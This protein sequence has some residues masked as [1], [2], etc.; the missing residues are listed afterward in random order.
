MR[1]VRFGGVW[2]ALLGLW[3]CDD[4]GEPSQSQVS[5]EF[6]SPNRPGQLLGCAEDA[7]RSTTDRLE[8]DVSVLV[9]LKG[10]PSEGL[11]VSLREVGF[12]DSEV[13]APVPVSG[14]V[15]FPGYP[16][17]LGDLNLAV[18]VR[19][20]NTVLASSER[21][22]L[23]ALNPADPACGAVPVLS[24]V[25]PMDGAVLDGAGD[26]N[27][28]DDLQLE[29]AVG[30]EGGING[31][32]RL[33]IDEVEAG[34]AAPVDGVARFPV[35]LPI[36]NG[37]GSFVL[38]AVATSAAGGE[39]RTEITVQVDIDGCT[40][41]VTPADVGAGCDFTT[42][43]DED[44]ATD[45]IQVTFAAETTCGQVAFQVN[46]I[47]TPLLEAVD[48]QVSSVLTLR[49]GVNEI[50][51]TATTAGGLATSV[52]P[53]TLVVGPAQPATLDLA[54]AAGENA[55]DLTTVEAEG[56]VW[57]LS[58]SSTDLPVGTEVRLVLDPA[59][60][61]APTGV[62]AE[63]GT[64][65]AVVATPFLCPAT[66]R[67][68]ATDACGEAVE[69]PLY[70]VCFDGVRPTLTIIEPGDGA[71]PVDADAEAAGLQTAVR[72]RVA[73]ERPLP[74]F[75]Y[76]IRVECGRGDGD[77]ADRTTVSALRSSG[78]AQG[79]VTVQVTF[80]VGDVGD[81]RCRATDLAGPNGAV[82]PAV[83]YRIEFGMPTFRLVDPSPIGEP[84][85]SADG[86][87]RIAG[88]GAAL[89]A[90]NA[91]M[92]A[93]IAAAGQVPL[94]VV[95]AEEGP[96]RFGATL[97]DAGQPG[98]LLDG[99]YGVT[100]AGVSD[101]GPVAVNP[102]GAV[103]FVV[104]S[105]APV[106][107]LVGPAGPLGAAND[108]NNDLSDCIQ[109]P[110]TLRLTDDTA[111]EICF[112]I[113]GEA[114]IC[115]TVDDAGQLVTEPVTFGAGDNLLTLRAV[116][117]AR[118]QG[119]VQIPVRA[120][121][122]GADERRLF[123]TNPGDGE[124]VRQAQDADAA[125]AGCQLDLRA[126][127]AGFPDDAQFVVCTNVAQGM[128]PAACAGESSPNAAP[129]RSE[130]GAGQDIVCPL[131]LS[132]GSHTLRIVSTAADRTASAPITVRADCTGPTVRAITLL[133]DDG[134]ACINRQ[135]RIEDLQNG[136]PADVTVRFEV[137]GVEDGRAL[138]VRRQPEDQNLGLAPVMGGVGTL[139]VRL[140]PGE[141]SLSIAGTDAALNPLPAPGGANLVAVRVDTTAPVPSV[142]AADGQCFNA[143]ADTD[144]ATDGLQLQLRV[145]TGREPGE[146]VTVEV[147]TEGVALP[148]AET[149]LAE[150]IENLTL[151]EGEVG[152]VAT[153]TD[154]CGN[155][156]SASGFE[157]IG[158][159][160]DWGAPIPL[161][162]QADTIAPQPS[163]V[164]VAEGGVYTLADDADNDADN[165][166]QIAAQVAF[167]G[168]GA[169]AG[170]PIVIRTG[171]VRLGTIP[172][173]LLANGAAP[174]DALLTLP[175]GPHALSATVTDACGNP[176]QS[177]VINVQAVTGGC[178][179]RIVGLD[180]FLGPLDGVV[181]AGGL[182]LDVAAQ[183]DVLCAV[184]T[185]RLLV[186]GQPVGDPVL[187]GLGNVVFGDVVLPPGEHLLAVRV[188]LAGQVTESVPTQVF[189][190]LSAATVRFL[191]PAGAEPI[192]LVDDVD[193][194]PGQQVIVVAEVQEDQVDT[195][196]EATLSIG[197]V[198]VAGPLAVG[199]GSPTQ[200]DFGAVTVPAGLSTLE[201]CVADAVG[202]EGCATLQI[203]ADPG[204]PG[205]VDP[206]VE[207]LDRRRPRVRYRFVA[208]GE[209]G[210]AGGRPTRYRFRHAPTPILTEADW[211][212]AT[213]FLANGATVDPG[214]I[215][216]INVTGLLFTQNS[217][218]VAIRAVDE[219]GRE[220][221]WVSVLVDLT[222]PTAE[223]DLTPAGGWGGDDF[224]N[225]GSLVE[226]LGDVDGDGLGDLLVYGNRIVGQ[227][228][229]AVVYGAANPAQA[230]VVPLVADGATIYSATDG[231]GVGDL[232]GDG[233]PDLALLGYDATFST[234]RVVLYF[235]CPVGGGC[236]RDDVA[237]PDAVLRVP[238]R[239]ASFV[240]GIG[241]FYGPG[242][243][244]DLLIGGSPAGGGNTAFVIDGRANWPAD[245]DVTAL[246]ANTGLIALS[247]PEP[248]A[249]VFATRAGDLDGDGFADLALAA[250]GNLEAT[251][252]F[253]GAAVMP[254]TL[255]FAAAGD[256][257]VRLV[258]PCDPDPG[259]FGS[260]LRGGVDLTGNGRPDLLVGARSFKQ[261]AVF[262]EDLQFLDC[263]GRAEVQF[264]VNFD[265]AG[266]IDRDGDVDL[267]VTHRDD[268]GRPQDAF[269]Y[270]NDGAGRFGG[271][272][273]LPREPQARFSVPNRIR[274]GA[275]GVG[276]FNGDGLP[277]LATVY[278]LAGGALRAVLHY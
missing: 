114:E 82:N 187:V 19:R 192:S 199:A 139:V 111:T 49:A 123:I 39:V 216:T 116:D 46:G 194:A 157:Q 232:N 122:C 6:I 256:R 224:F 71:F 90:N 151:Q 52:A 36:G 137:D 221:P 77:F 56:P 200:V 203:S 190:D 167:A 173:Q 179:S 189:V 23:T 276:D 106:L 240:S 197:G 162:I 250:G 201:V 51:A 138:S 73:D 220:G 24:F 234:T 3:A 14:T 32:V 235:G 60:D 34:T 29:V 9:R 175:D 112:R 163:L 43:I 67:A 260:W 133:E 20:G 150:I 118:N 113:N 158:G 208:P 109:T 76:E 155:V 4:T 188:S 168:D 17:D 22:V 134:D 89:S 154:A 152:L 172:A 143:A 170:Q 31:D 262:N 53:Y 231:R 204:A 27:L 268:Q 64:F 142:S 269:L 54:L 74:R 273:A 125:V 130:G 80:P 217:Y 8:Y 65:T 226:G 131:S 146:T 265:F 81:L 66:L 94:E 147:A 223:F 238:G 50:E 18:E 12:A 127:G 198:V 28:A 255:A 148:A 233:A 11:T 182:R 21:R 274:F 30:V 254:N 196:R 140:Q 40:L 245:L 248:N 160:D 97:G 153:V 239:V 33:E 37:Q 267:I 180:P 191:Q 209:D 121:G 156:G 61:P 253:Y 96:D 87:V 128:G 110:L 242:S 101:V 263:F 145:R 42:A 247:V 236:D 16:L 92:T 261:I 243:F 119:L 99:T 241:D 44:A 57:T 26:T 124:F 195:D 79:V 93:S 159:A 186:D 108:A 115:G 178:S 237:T 100:V 252:V 219:G 103:A 136:G 229:A 48:G 58:G 62:V 10:N 91:R 211:Q 222:M 98:A 161:S 184:G 78:D 227:A 117:C 183:V 266:D 25:S 174:V 126:G 120:E 13:T 47:A 2:L 85:C 5:V 38:A 166:L 105:A 278:K 171:D 86:R 270:A 257:A 69:S 169:E 230:A 205:L 132:D 15:T 35:T 272:V 88:E 149:D 141:T 249:G 75:D 210:D 72:V 207:I 277:D 259:T 84:T 225:A 181:E 176:G 212:A 107:A 215:Q 104:D 95:L 70:D 271:R 41:T 83:G 218:H 102:A 7:D 258:N 213:F 202:N 45:G 264:G 55:F 68:Q 1:F 165:G 144:P 185:A 206:Q 59:L 129:C 228:A 135:E 177:A 275:A 63:D 193:P 244:D 164:G 251:Y 214:Q 246:D